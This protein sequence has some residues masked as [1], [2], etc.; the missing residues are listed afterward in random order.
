MCIEIESFFTSALGLSAS[1][2]VEKVNL[3]T[4]CRRIDFDLT[5]DAKR[6]ACPVCGLANQGIHDRQKRQWR[7]LDFFQYEA[8]FHAVVPRIAC[9][10]CGKTTHRCKYLGRAKAVA[11]RPCLKRW[12]CLCAGSCPCAKLLR[13]TDKQLWRRIERY[14]DAARKFD[15]MSAV[16]VIGIDETSLRKGQN[17]IT[18]VHDL[19]KKRL[20]FACEGKDHQT[21]CNFA[22]D[23]QAC[24]AWRHIT[25]RPPSARPIE[26]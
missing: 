20:L 15:D 22:N 10:G 16:R 21:V 4:A 6:L 7:H 1:W 14:V 5:C 19:E 25:R 9:S 12:H 3:D 26:V 24:C 8:W 23:L 18:V 13:C 17:Y 11:L 2:R